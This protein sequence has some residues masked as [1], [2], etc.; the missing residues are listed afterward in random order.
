MQMTSLS[1]LLNAAPLPAPAAPTAP[2]TSSVGVSKPSPSNGEPGA[3]KADAHPFAAMLKRQQ[4]I[5]P[6]TSSPAAGTA[7]VNISASEPAPTAEDTQPL[8]NTP[9]LATGTRSKRGAEPVT[10]VKVEHPS[11]DAAKAAAGG[12]R[13]E[14]NTKAAK[15]GTDP[16]DGKDL[17]VA[18]PQ[19]EPVQCPIDLG[20]S[21]VAK[22]AGVAADQ[23]K[24]GAAIE[25]KDTTAPAAAW[26]AD[27]RTSTGPGAASADAGSEKVEGASA[28][29]RIALRADVSGDKLEAVKHVALD[30]RSGRVDAPTAAPSAFATTLAQLGGASIA[31]PSAPVDVTVATPMNAPEFAQAFGLQVSLLVADGVQRA[32]LHLNP[33]D[34][35]PVSIEITLDGTQAQVDFGAD[36]ASTRHAIE[37][38]LPE[39]ASALQDAGFTLHGGG[40][41]QHSARQQES[42]DGSDASFGQGSGRPAPVEAGSS[43]GSTAAARQRVAMTGG[44]D[45]YA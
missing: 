32:E 41:S 12:D 26:S 10:P 34:M 2:P 38:G 37:A 20:L 28:A 6:E 16:T 21:A 17:V 24:G 43:T 33:A 35:G 15:D 8:A 5:E 42:G 19:P 39:L 14:K 22:R 9:K 11:V 29:S 7:R 13:D 1:T 44:V 23:G 40:V 25:G 30:D 4:A 18:T 45:V 3:G 31:A 36:L 27:A